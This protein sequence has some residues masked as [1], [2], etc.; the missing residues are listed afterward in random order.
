[1]QPREH[2]LESVDF[3]QDS[4]CRR[5]TSVILPPK[6]CSIDRTTGSCSKRA[7]NSCVLASADDPAA[8]AATATDSILAQTRT[9]RPST[10]LEATRIFSSESRVSSKPAKVCLAGEKHSR[11]SAPSS[12]H[13][14]ACSTSSARNFCC[15]WMADLISATCSSVRPSA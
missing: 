12:S 3:H 15:D 2:L 8:A 7:R 1:P 10:L 14:E 9:E 4:S 13:R 5:R 6:R 11:S